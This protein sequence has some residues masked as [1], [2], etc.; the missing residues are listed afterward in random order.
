MGKFAGPAGDTYRGQASLIDRSIGKTCSEC[1]LY[2]NKEGFN[3]GLK[4]NRC[5]KYYAMMQAWGAQFPPD[6][7]A[8]QYFEPRAGQ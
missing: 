5:L 1:V 3:E 8:C 4:K 6:A 2:T 7:T